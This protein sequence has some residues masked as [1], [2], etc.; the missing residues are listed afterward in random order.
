MWCSKGS[1]PSNNSGGGCE[2]V[3]SGEWNTMNRGQCCSPGER[4]RPVRVS[5]A[6]ILTCL[7]RWGL[8]SDQT[9]FSYLCIC[10]SWRRHKV[11]RQWW[12]WWQWMPLPGT[13]QTSLSCRMVDPGETWDCSRSRPWR[14]F[15]SETEKNI[16]WSEWDVRRSVFLQQWSLAT[17]RE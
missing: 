1:M 2:T 8:V 16:N 4:H 3:S 11:W 13:R 10:E 14:E 15:Q 12:W 5:D 9:I 7:Q 17:C 6:S